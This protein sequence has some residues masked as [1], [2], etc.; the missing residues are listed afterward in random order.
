MISRGRAL[1]SKLANSV[2]RD[3]LE[4]R[5]VTTLGLIITGANYWRVEEQ[6]DALDR[7]QE[8]SVKLGRHTNPIILK[9][10]AINKLVQ[11]DFVQ[12]EQIGKQLV[13]LGEETKDPTLPLQG[14]QLLGITYSWLGA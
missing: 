14:H 10:L 8:L 1:I 11:N 12:I 9:A 5:L 7:A 6:L 2:Q 3:E 13:E 4:L